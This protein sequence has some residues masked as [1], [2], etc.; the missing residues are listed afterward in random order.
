MID[1]RHDARMRQ[2]F[3]ACVTLG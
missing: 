1:I 2:V 3:S